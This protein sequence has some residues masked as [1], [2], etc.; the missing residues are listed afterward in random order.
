MELKPTKTNL[1]MLTQLIDASVRAEEQKRRQNEQPPKLEIA[2]E[3]LQKF[4]G[5]MQ[6]EKIT[7]PDLEVLTPDEK[8]LFSVFLTERLNGKKGTD[9]DIHIAKVEAIVTDDTN[10]DIHHSNRSKI[11]N[12]IASS[13][14][15]NGRMPGNAE[16][17][18]VAGLSRNTVQK[19]MKQFDSTDDFIALVKE[20]Q[21]AKTNIVQSVIKAAV[22]GDMRAAKLYLGTVDKLPTQLN[23]TTIINQQ[24]NFI[25]M[26]GVT[27]N[28][29]QLPI[30]K[31]QQIKEI[32]SGVL[33]VKEE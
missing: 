6:L 30:D 24:N 18:R 32:I 22:N 31:Q 7:K 25:Q 17:A 8:E 11:N 29:T 9:L 27:V 1:K 14:K 16:I 21:Y 26:D 19:H 23:N 2:P 20:Y 5:L 13:F 12:A 10:E 3:T 4:E 28:F 15:K 33:V